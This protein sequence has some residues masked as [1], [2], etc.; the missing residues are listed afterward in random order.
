MARVV[1]E[2]KGVVV[3]DEWRV[4]SGEKEATARKGEKLTTEDAESHG[5]SGGGFGG[6]ASGENKAMEW[7]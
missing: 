6:V 7:R 4:T 5:G 1:G 3:S 2:V